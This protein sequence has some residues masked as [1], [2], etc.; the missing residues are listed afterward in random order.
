MATWVPIAE[1]DDVPPDGRRCFQHED[2]KLVVFRVGDDVHVLED[3]CPHVGA[4]LSEGKREALTIE[5]PWHHVVYSLTTGAALSEPSWGP[6]SRFPARVVDGVIEI[7]W[8]KR[9]YPFPHP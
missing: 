7:D 9:R 3:F 6:A 5:C 1:L 4:P 8:S 2:K